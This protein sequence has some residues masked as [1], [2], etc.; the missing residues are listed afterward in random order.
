LFGLS[1]VPEATVINAIEYASFDHMQEMERLSLYPARELKL[2]NNSDDPNA[3]K[4]RRGKVGENRKEL[5]TEDLAYL[6]DI[7]ARTSVPQ[8]WVYFD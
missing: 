8:D 5:S 4:V 3:F 1:N 7:V 6:D 2:R